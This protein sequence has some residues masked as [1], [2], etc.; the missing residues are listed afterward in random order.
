MFD[1][2]QKSA[3]SNNKIFSWPSS[4]HILNHS[5]TLKVIC[6]LLAVEEV[7]YH[8]AKN[9]CPTPGCRGQGHAKGYE[10]TSH[11]RLVDCPYNPQNLEN[12]QKP[13]RLKSMR[14]PSRTYSTDSDR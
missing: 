7:S 4:D 10:F 13:D 1:F 8:M 3:D 11:D 9:K 12:D 2:I 6:I 14:R 5:W